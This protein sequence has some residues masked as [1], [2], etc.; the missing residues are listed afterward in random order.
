MLIPKDVFPIKAVASLETTSYAIEGIL[1]A[2][3]GDEGLAVATDGRRLLELRWPETTAARKAHPTP[4]RRALKPVPDY[5][6]VV[7][8]APWTEAAKL[9]GQHCQH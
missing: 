3:K 6:T 2:R 1:L 4:D 7:P 8:A 9:G 5:R